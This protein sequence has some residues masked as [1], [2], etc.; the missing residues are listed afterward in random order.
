ML[1]YTQEVPERTCECLEEPVGD[2]D[3]LVAAEPEL[4]AE[5]VEVLQRLRGHVVEVAEV[6]HRVQDREEQRR[7]RDNLTGIQTS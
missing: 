3:L 4:R 1:I 5:A 2:V 6:T 7:A